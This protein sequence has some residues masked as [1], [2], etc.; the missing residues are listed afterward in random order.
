MK[1][2]GYGEDY[3]YMPM[4]IKINLIEQ[5]FLPEEIKGTTLYQPG[6]QSK[7]KKY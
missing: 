7:R 6:G 1:E 4:I 3:K 2:I 5:E